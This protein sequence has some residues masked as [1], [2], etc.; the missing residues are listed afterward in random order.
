M[1][2][3]FPGELDKVKIPT[4]REVIVLVRQ[5]EP[6]SRIRGVLHFGPDSL[7]PLPVNES[8]DEAIAH[9]LFEVATRREAAPPDVQALVALVEKYKVPQ[10]AGS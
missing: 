6:G 1:R 9:A 2:T 7:L 10:G 3:P 5:V 8:S 4:G